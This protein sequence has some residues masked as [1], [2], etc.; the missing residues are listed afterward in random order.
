[1]DEKNSID[2]R[3]VNFI[4]TE[5]VFTLAT[6]I[7]NKPHC[8]ICYYAYSEKLNILIFKSSRSSEHIKQGLSNTKI[9]AAIF[10]SNTIATSKGV[11]AEGNFIDGTEKQKNEAK[12]IYYLKFPFALSFSGE[13]WLIEL[14]K[15]KF[16]DNSLGFSKKIYWEKQN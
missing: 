13:L 11:Q 4:E 12:K 7:D 16:V 10:N 15:I 5:K 8:A 6:C 3:I 9:A 2:T 1:M 14:T